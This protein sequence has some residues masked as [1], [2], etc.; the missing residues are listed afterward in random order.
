MHRTRIDE[1]ITTYSIDW[2]L[3]RMPAVDRNLLRLAIYELLWAPDVPG[4]VAI[5]EAVE[6]ARELS[7]EESPAFINGVLARVLVEREAL[8][9][10]ES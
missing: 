6:H 7:T 3:D 9:S 10:S 4:A 1:V 2:T 8:L 5:D